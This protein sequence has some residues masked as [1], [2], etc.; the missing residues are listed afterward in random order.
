MLKEHEFWW[1]H[2]SEEQRQFIYDHEN[3]QDLNI[4]EQYLKREVTRKLPGWPESV[5]RHV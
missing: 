5:M 3:Q 2:L 1:T 4:E